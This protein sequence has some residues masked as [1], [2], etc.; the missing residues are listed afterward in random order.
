MASK[1]SARSGSKMRTMKRKTSRRRTS[2][3]NR[4][5][6]TSVQTMGSQSASISGSF[7]GAITASGHLHIAP[8]AKCQASV[9]ANSVQV[10]GMVKGRLVAQKRMKLGSKCQIQGEIIADKL[11]ANDG[12]SF[13]GVCKLGR[14]RKAA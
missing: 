9:N 1:K 14:M 8:G 2:R 10:D 7:S 5:T 6:M 4:S 3:M 13:Y 11:V 12:A